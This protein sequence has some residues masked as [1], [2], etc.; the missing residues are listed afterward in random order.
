MCFL[1]LLG[2][3]RCLT[4]NGEGGREFIYIPDPSWQVKDVERNTNTVNIKINTEVQLHAIKEADLEVTTQK[5]EYIHVLS[6]HVVLSMFMSCHQATVQMQVA[7][8]SLE[9]VVQ[10]RYLGA[11]VTN[12]NCIHKEITKD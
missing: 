11:M 6:F 4:N 12:E 5:I 1:P 7:N 2:K 3:S 9:N 8:K 10:F